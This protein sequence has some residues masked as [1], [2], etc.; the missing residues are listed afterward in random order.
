MDLLH[1]TAPKGTAWELLVAV[2]VIIV[3]PWLADACT[4]PA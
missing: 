1:L 3:A 4:C 2:V